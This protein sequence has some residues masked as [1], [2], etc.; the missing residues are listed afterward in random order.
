MSDLVDLRKGDRSRVVRRA[1]HPEDGIGGMVFDLRAGRIS[2][3]LLT[4]AYSGLLTGLIFFG[5]YAVASRTTGI[6]ANAYLVAILC[7]AA[8]IVIC[9]FA[10]FR[11]G[12]AGGDAA[13]RKQDIAAGEVDELILDVAEAKAFREPEHGGLMYFLKLGDGRVF[14]DVS[15]SDLPEAGWESQVDMIH[16]ADVP[17]ERLHLLYG[18]ASGKML[19]TR[20]SGAPVH[21]VSVNMIKNSPEYW[22]TP[23]TFRKTA[24][25]EIETHFAAR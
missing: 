14:Y 10:I 24:W 7:L 9:A 1:V 17:R 20:Y 6:A 13:L 21:P 3:L 15:G 2:S 12:P 22:P 8:G 19:G 23:F 5:V 18:T 25:S 4:V 11:R 16:E